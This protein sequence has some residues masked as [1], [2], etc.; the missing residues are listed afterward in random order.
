MELYIY[1]YQ[2]V[3]IPDENQIR[4]PMLFGFVGL[5]N[6]ICLFPFLFILDWLNLEVITLMTL[7]TLIALIALVALVMLIT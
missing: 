2:Q 6:F 3:K 4:M 1:I 5:L 7:I